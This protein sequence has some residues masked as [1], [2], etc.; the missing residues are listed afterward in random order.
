M[1]GYACGTSQQPLQFPG[2]GI[3]HVPSARPCKQDLTFLDYV[4][5]FSRYKSMP[6]C[7]GSTMDVAV[8]AVGEESPFFQ[9]LECWVFVERTVVVELG[10]LK[11]LRAVELRC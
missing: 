7:F 2:V 4:T 5:A 3:G 1:Q 8:V 6:P 10:G 9:C 11:I